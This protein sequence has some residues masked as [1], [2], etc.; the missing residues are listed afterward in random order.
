MCASAGDALDSAQRAAVVDVGSRLWALL[1]VTLV[2]AASCLPEQVNCCR[3]Q[4]EAPVERDVF[5]VFGCLAQLV[6]RTSNITG[7]FSA[8]CFLECDEVTL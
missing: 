7:N 2:R 8:L 3:E 4:G 5:N 6:A 1:D